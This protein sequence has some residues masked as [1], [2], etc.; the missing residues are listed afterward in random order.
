MGWPLPHGIYKL[1]K[2]GGDPLL[3][4]PVLVGM[5]KMKNDTTHK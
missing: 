3:R 1:N 5:G 2:M 4:F